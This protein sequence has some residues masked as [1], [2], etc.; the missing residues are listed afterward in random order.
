MVVTGGAIE[1]HDERT[2]DRWIERIGRSAHRDRFLV[3]GCLPAIEAER[4]LSRAD[5][6]VVTERPIAE[7]LL[8]SSARVCRWL[9]VGLPVICTRLSE[10]GE[11]VELDGLGWTYAPGDADDLARA[12]LEAVAADRRA[13]RPEEL[14]SAASRACKRWSD[15]ATTA[16][17]RRWVEQA[18]RAPDAGSPSVL[19]SLHR[20]GELAEV[21]EENRRLQAERD[22]LLEEYHSVRSELGL[23]HQSRMWSLWMLWLGI[24]RALTW[25]LRRLRGVS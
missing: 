20:V 16:A 3:K 25:P 17:V 11:A 15:T 18:G 2:H 7:R 13:S 1:G 22:R 5:A 24:R 23:I 10:L 19:A 21:V 6:G 14:M 9:G 12:I 8:G 4:Y